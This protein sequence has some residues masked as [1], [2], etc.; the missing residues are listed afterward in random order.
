MFQQLEVRRCKMNSSRAGLNQ[1]TMA[2]PTLK[3]MSS[4]AAAAAAANVPQGLMSIDALI[5]LRKLLFLYRFPEGPPAAGAL[6]QMNFFSFG[7]DIYPG[8]FP[9]SK[10]SK[11]VMAMVCDGIGRDFVAMA[12]P[13]PCA[14]DQIR[15]AEQVMSDER[16]ELKPRHEV[17]IAPRP[18]DRVAACLL[19][20]LSR[21]SMARA[22]EDQQAL[23]TSGYLA[24]SIDTSPELFMRGIIGTLPGRPSEPL[25]GSS[26]NIPAPGLHKADAA[27]A[28]GKACNKPASFL[29]TTSLDLGPMP[30]EVQPSTGRQTGA[31][32]PHLPD[33]GASS[34][35]ASSSRASE[36]QLGHGRSRVDV[37]DSRGQSSATSAALATTP[38]D[39][40]A[41]AA[42]GTSSKASPPGHQK[43]LDGSQHGLC[44]QDLRAWLTS[45]P[46]PS[47]KHKPASADRQ[48]QP[49]P[50]KEYLGPVNTW[51]PVSD[52]LPDADDDGGQF[53]MCSGPVDIHALTNG[54]E[55][56]INEINSDTSAK[57]QAGRAPSL[58][59]TPS[60]Q[61]LGAQSTS[62]DQAAWA[63]ASWTQAARNLRRMQPETCAAF[64]RAHS[65]HAQHRAPSRAPSG[66][67]STLA[68]TKAPPISQ[69][70]LDEAERKAQA[71]AEA[72]LEEE[73][74]E[75]QASCKRDEQKAKRKQA[76]A[77]KKKSKG[78]AAAPPQASTPVLA[79]SAS[80]DEQ[81]NPDFLQADEQVASGLQEF[82]D[83]Q[84]AQGECAARC[85][86][87]SAAEASKLAAADMPT[88]DVT[89]AYAKDSSAATADKLALAQPLQSQAVS[90]SEA[91]PVQADEAAS[92]T[93]QG[94]QRALDPLSGDEIH[95]TQGA[96]QALQPLEQT[97]MHRAPL[98]R[99]NAGA[100]EDA[101]TILSHLQPGTSWHMI[102]LDSVVLTSCWNMWECD[103][104][105]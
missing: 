3:A 25:Y 97:P 91:S 22:P 43:A 103:H 32:S 93:L 77:S 27:G 65:D 40:H 74:A 95:S 17:G 8:V 76:R 16:R 41:Q 67:Q 39:A 81:R 98:R 99:T 55:H 47:S 71:A 42:P 78:P 82:Q 62:I 69:A 46:G 33:Q 19:M 35:S 26:C 64:E 68:A 4:S 14:R 50:G 86:H 87:A 94:P 29:P 31:R 5:R 73:D 10:W 84:T 102:C 30:A 101:Q 12:W 18:T 104:S 34:K 9:A 37:E 56:F 63:Q 36:V 79:N 58:S 57:R 49:G 60:S 88:A 59:V 52:V 11:Q 61:P 48:A 53:M 54:F 90:C 23:D 38:S 51:R 66:V 44:S 70:E 100:A 92:T 89:V 15:L 45:P 72:L 2:F 6:S 96:Q 75:R 24:S 83:A 80:V 20:G 105:S 85:S 13:L 21:A 1:H 7:E 28:L